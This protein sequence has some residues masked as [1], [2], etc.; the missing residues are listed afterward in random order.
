MRGLTPPLR[1][2][3]TGTAGLSIMAVGVAAA[4]GWLVLCHVYAPEGARQAFEAAAC[5]PHVPAWAKVCFVA[6]VLAVGVGASALE[7]SGFSDRESPGEKALGST[8]LHFPL[9]AGAGAVLFEA[10]WLIALGAAAAGFA[11]ALALGAALTYART[12]R[13]RR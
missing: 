4:I 9:A 3:G 6:V 1:Q 10:G 12:W 2:R 8:R 7:W 5:V 11:V 13:E